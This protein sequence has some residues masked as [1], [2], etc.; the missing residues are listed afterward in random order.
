VTTKLILGLVLLTIATNCDGGSVSGNK[1]ELNVS[2]VSKSFTTQRICIGRLVLDAPSD[3][4]LTSAHPA[5]FGSEFSVLQTGS[6]ADFDQLIERRRGQIKSLPSPTNRSSALFADVPHPR[7]HVFGF[8][9]DDL[10]FEVG[11]GS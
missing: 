8:T 1:E 10:A 3:F 4:T 7:G 2:D 11:G 5:I 9:S 6:K